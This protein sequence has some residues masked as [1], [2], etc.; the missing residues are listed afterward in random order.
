MK[1]TEVIEVV[2]KLK[3]TTFLRSGGGSWRGW[4]RTGRNGREPVESKGERKLDTLRCQRAMLAHPPIAV[5][6]VLYGKY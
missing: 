1:W 2:K 5:L 4:S 6:S 3:P